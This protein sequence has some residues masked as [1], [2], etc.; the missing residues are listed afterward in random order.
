MQT[1]MTWDL[2]P[3]REN[4]ERVFGREQYDLFNPCLRSAG[5][6][7]DFARYHYGEAHR[8]MNEVIGDN[9]QIEMVATILGAH[10][11]EPGAFN[12]A[13]FQAAAHT[14]AC[15]QSMHAL[16]DSL[17]HTLYYGL[18]FNLDKATV[19]K[20]KA[21]NAYRVR[22]RLPSGPMRDAMSAW[23]DDPGFTYLSALNNCSKHRSMVSVGYSVDMTGE[24]EL[25]H[26]LKFG[27]FDYEDEHYPQR[28][29]RPTLINEYQRQETLFHQIGHA[30]NDAT[31]ALQ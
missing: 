3:L 19:L 9:P 20:P 15:V 7:R 26:G 2:R 25:P 5:D 10:D 21:I 1:D 13:R 14:V 4:V 18:G 30:L 27:M 8:L 12:W 22:E 6:R 11:K 16:V 24:D 17:A 29:V 28:W 31:A 23:I